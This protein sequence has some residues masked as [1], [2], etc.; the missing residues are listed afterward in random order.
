MND[1]RPK[2]V[3]SL[4]RGLNHRNSL[5]GLLLL[6]LTACDGKSERVSAMQQLPKVI[7]GKYYLSEDLNDF[8]KLQ[9]YYHFGMKD[10]DVWPD[11]Y[12]ETDNQ[13]VF[14]FTQLSGHDGYNSKD[15]IETCTILRAEFAELVYAR[16]RDFNVVCKGVK[17]DNSDAYTFGSSHFTYDN[18]RYRFG[19]F[20]DGFRRLKFTDEDGVE[21]YFRRVS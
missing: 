17:A 11:I 20:G 4:G 10:R 8:D 9:K 15:N 3:I 13:I 6:L 12:G 7:F 19:L 21:L 5:F 14:H 18:K 2:R 1:A 16:F